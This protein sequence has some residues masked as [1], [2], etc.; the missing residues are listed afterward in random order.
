LY[1]ARR[2]PPKHQAIIV[3]LN[4]RTAHLGVPGVVLRSAPTVLAIDAMP[5]FHAFDIERQI[6]LIHMRSAAAFGRRL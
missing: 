5:I 6:E 2:S 4:P 1:G 3:D